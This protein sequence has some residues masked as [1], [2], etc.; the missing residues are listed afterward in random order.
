MLRGSGAPPAEGLAVARKKLKEEMLTIWQAQWEV[1][2][3]TNWTRRLIPNVQGWL[4]GHAIGGLDYHLAQLLSGHGVF[5]KFR[6]R[7]G[8]SDT[9]ECWDCGHEMDDAEHLLLD[10]ARWDAERA[11]LE[12]E[13]GGRLTVQNVVKLANANGVTWKALKSFARVTMDHRIRR[14]NEGDRRE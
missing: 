9:T 4:K 14:E 11:S 7:I 1:F 12:K 10:C 8:K 3:D 6:A 5:N 13:L 2:K